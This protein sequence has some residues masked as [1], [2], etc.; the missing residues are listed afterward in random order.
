MAKETNKRTILI[1]NHSKT[2]HFGELVQ[3]DQSVLITEKL[4]NNTH[5]HIIVLPLFAPHHVI[6]NQSTQ[7]F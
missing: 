2:H 4:K 5:T 1:K 6:T 7:N 3:C